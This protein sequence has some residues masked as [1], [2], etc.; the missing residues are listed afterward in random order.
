MIFVVILH[1]G[2]LFLKSIATILMPP[3]IFFQGWIAMPLFF[4]MWEENIAALPKI[5]E[6]ITPLIK[7]C[8]QLCI[9]KLIIYKEKE[10][11]NNIR[12]TGTNT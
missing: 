12:V 1:I 2:K 11:E 9:R 4:A 8:T 3:A 10:R 5:W 7:Y 6:N